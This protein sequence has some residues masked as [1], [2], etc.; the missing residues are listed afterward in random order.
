MLQFVGTDTLQFI[1]SYAG[2]I[3]PIYQYLVSD[4]FMFILE[5]DDMARLMKIEII[6][7]LYI[8][9]LYIYMVKWVLKE[10][11]YLCKIVFYVAFVTTT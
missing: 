6:R 7:K 10:K 3:T 8:Y 2:M 11:I 5:K 1:V 9:I 4:D